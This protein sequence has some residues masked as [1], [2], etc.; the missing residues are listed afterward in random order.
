MQITE[1]RKKRV[2]DLYFNRHKTY[3]EISQIEKMSRLDIHAIVKEENSRLQKY[4]HQQQQ[5]KPEQNEES[6]SDRS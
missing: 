3:A 6:R 1:D 4:K 5:L 2:I